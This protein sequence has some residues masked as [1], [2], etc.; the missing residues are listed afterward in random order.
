MKNLQLSTSSLLNI[1]N[2]TINIPLTSMVSV[3]GE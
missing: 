2:N 1:E 3:K